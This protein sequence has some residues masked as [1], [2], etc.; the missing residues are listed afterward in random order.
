MWTAPVVKTHSVLQLNKW[1]FATSGIK[2]L[3]QF[4]SGIATDG[5]Q[6]HARE[7]NPFG[8][9]FLESRITD[10]ELKSFGTS[11]V[12]SLWGLTACVCVPVAFVAAFAATFAAIV[13]I[14]I[15]EILPSLQSS[16]QIP[17]SLSFPLP[18]QCD[19]THFLSLF[20]RFFPFLPCLRLSPFLPLLLFLTLWLS[21][22]SLYLSSS[23]SVLHL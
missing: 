4:R 9:T 19:H 1:I 12:R 10:K 14:V 21:S 15:A 18:P 3:R 6:H 5:F 23:S 2:S 7:K 11:L 20:L 17:S 8:F 22:G 13:I 16:L